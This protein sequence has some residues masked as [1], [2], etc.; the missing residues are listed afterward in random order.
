MQV[1]GHGVAH[2]GI[3]NFPGDHGA[4]R[5]AKALANLRKVSL[6]LRHTQVGL[7]LRAMLGSGIWVRIGGK[8]YRVGSV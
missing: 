1:L 4:S 7:G 8:Q 2:E 6:D 5:L 3:G